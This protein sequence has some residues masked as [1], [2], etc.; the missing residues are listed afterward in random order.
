MEVLAAV[1]VSNGMGKGAGTEGRCKQNKQTNIAS[2][3]CKPPL[4]PAAGHILK[5]NIE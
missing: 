1:L 5:D 3:F 4:P 2:F